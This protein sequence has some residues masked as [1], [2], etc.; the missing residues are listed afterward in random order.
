VFATAIIPL[1]V[2]WMTMTLRRILF[3][4]TAV[5]LCARAVSAAA[6]E[7]VVVTASPPDP[8]GNA[9]FSVATVTAADLR[10]N[11][12]LDHALSQVPGLSLFRRDSSLS[13]NPTTQ[14]VS[15]R[16]IA[17]SGAGRALV[18]LDGVPQ[19][20]PFGGW[21][22]WSSLPPEDIG[23]AQVVRGAGAGP[24]GAGALTGT[25]ALK[26]ARGDGLV[27]ADASLAELNGKRA[28]ASG[29]TTLGPISLFAS[30]SDE[31][32]DGWIAISPAQRGAADNAVT[33]HARNASLRAEAEPW[34]GT[35]LSLRLGAYG[36]NRDSGLV[37]AASS[38]DGVTASLTLAH[39]QSV[40]D[41][42]WRVQAWMRNTGFSNTS[43]T[44]LPG[45][46]GTTLSN[47]QYSTPAIGWGFNAALRGSWSWLDWELGGD[48][49]FAQG[50]SKEHFQAVGGVFTQGRMSGGRTVVGGLY[51]ETAAHPSGTLL[52]TLGVR[53]DQWAS[54]GGHLIQTT[55][56][57]GVV[58]VNQATPSKSGIVPTA[59]L[60]VRQELGDGLY[61]RSAAYAGFRAPSLN[62][63][64]RPFR[65]GNNLTQANPGLTPEKLYGAEIG[66]GQDGETFGW[67]VTGFTNQLHGAITNVTVAHGPVTVSG[68]GTVPA[69]GLLIQR[70]NAGNIDA[71]GIESDAHWQATDWLTLTAAFDYV[72]AHVEGGAAAAQLTGKQPAQAP[73]TTITA[74]FRVV[75]LDRLTV[76]ANLRYE[77]TR[78]ADDQNTLALAP[79]T[80][81]DARI[82]YRLW[83]GLS[84]YVAGD[85]LF[86]ARV[87]T[88]ESA[89]F[90]TNYASPRV[91]RIGLSW[92]GAEAGTE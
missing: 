24:Y 31:A 71:Y 73:Q 41:L 40:D 79:A 49:R 84:A 87:A 59:R 92:T 88:T 12:E 9:A 19:N 53:A 22:I 54:T 16:S 10:D 66:A 48:A 68:L 21:V 55:L 37:G 14:G 27:A 8:V 52:I 67:D 58:T 72:D 42:G 15:L 74:G 60:G 82:S 78:F 63:L 5:A 85:N 81:V 36:E 50:D 51:A 39:Q 1:H 69:G 38:A 43:A 86:N 75:P 30:A 35:L 77:S 44:V 34:S 91:L 33:Y 4:G 61:L 13:A 90:V 83:N 32:S 7:T 89:D 23:G 11:T 26:E 76:G 47:D 70:Q 65:L 45:R 62:E 29:G 57:T 25:I 3:A 17:P 20:D 64:Y 46:T 18:T 6:I 80:T 28:A 2:H 56:A